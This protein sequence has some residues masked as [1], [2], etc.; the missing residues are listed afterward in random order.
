MH[1]LI[2]DV[3]FAS[4]LSIAKSIPRGILSYLDEEMI[5][6]HSLCLPASILIIS[7]G[8]FNGNSDIE[9]I[10]FERD[11]QLKEITSFAFA[12]SSL[13]SID[14]PDSVTVIG[15]Y[16][17]CGCRSLSSVNF[18]KMSNL[19]K[20]SSHAFSDSSLCTIRIPAST[21]TVVPDAFSGCN[22]TSFSVA[23]ESSYLSTDGVVLTNKDQT[24]WICCVR[25]A[26]HISVPESVVKIG[27]MCFKGR[28][29]LRCIVFPVNS[30]LRE[31][32]REA[33]ALTNIMHYVL[34]KSVES[35]GER[36]FMSRKESCPVWAIVETLEQEETLQG[37]AEEYLRIRLLS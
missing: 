22:V 14:I 20:I 30:N 17:F 4:D 2:A 9:I 1:K 29:S 31:I 7:E 12:E 28:W 11:S 36:C 25:L 6:V 15:E 16:C 18:G 8:V 34:P 3:S 19:R 10:T 32:G 37:V 13:V 26:Q 33:F 23:E 5:R 35:F 27:D 24:E 21:M